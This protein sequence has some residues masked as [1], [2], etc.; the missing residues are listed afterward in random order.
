MF[1]TVPAKAANAVSVATLLAAQL[2]GVNVS[3]ILIASGFVCIGVVG[4][5][6][7]DL[8]KT[9]ERGDKIQLARSVAWIGCGIV[10]SPFLAIVYL[11][12]LASIHWPVDAFALV[13]LMCISFAG[14]AGV[15][16]L[17]DFATGIV[18][19]RT[20][21]SASQLPDPKKGA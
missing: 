11:A 6:M 1:T 18:R 17:M 10:G 2:F 21:G 16:G 8:Q 12:L 20:G 13:A 5:G 14:P 3:D 7:L 4:R 9:I 19:A 15:T